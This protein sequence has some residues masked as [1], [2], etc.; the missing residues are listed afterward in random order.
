MF[1]DGKL[2][3]ASSYWGPWYQDTFNQAPDLS[4]AVVPLPTGPGGHEAAIMWWGWGINAKSEHP[5]EAWQ[6][7]K[8]LT[9]E[10]GQRFF[11]L[12]ALTGHIS[13]AEELQKVD[14][15]YW[16]VFLAEVPYQGRLDDMTTPFYTTCVVIPGS[17]LIGRLF[18]EG[19]ADMDI[20]AELD[21][22]VIEAD[23]CLAESTIE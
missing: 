7:L 16:G 8:W 18:M 15:P 2:A 17:E 14:D 3:I 22:F 4:W 9:T 1:S 20:Q 6:L 12:H 13:T 10:P 23:K 11:A 21:A 19:G 5:E